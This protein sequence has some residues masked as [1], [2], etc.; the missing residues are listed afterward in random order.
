LHSLLVS[1][2]R[3]KHKPQN[4]EAFWNRLSQPSSP[5]MMAGSSRTPTLRPSACSVTARPSWSAERQDAHAGA[6]QGGAGRLYRQLSGNRR[7]E[8][9]RYRPRGERP[10]QGR[11][12]FSASPLGERIVAGQQRL[13]HP[14]GSLAGP[15]DAVTKDRLGGVRHCSQDEQ[16]QCVLRMRSLWPTISTTSRSV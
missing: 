7:Q 1:R 6:L 10:P 16:S 9:H 2:L 11:D 8:D 4:F 14:G 13:D 3:R 12:E 5:S 15:S